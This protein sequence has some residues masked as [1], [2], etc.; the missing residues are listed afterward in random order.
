MKNKILVYDDN[1]PLCSWYSSLFVRCGLLPSDG[2][3]AFSTLDPSLLR[4]IDFNKSRNEIPLLDTGSGQVLY[5]IDALLEILGQRIS[6]IK[7][8]GH[9]QPVNWCLK[10]LYRFISYNRKVIVARKCGPGNIDCA[11]DMSYL[12]RVF[13]MLV[14][15]VNNTLLLFPLH[16]VVLASIPGFSL[17]TLQVQ[18]AHFS[19]VLINLVLAISFNKSM[20]IEYLGQVNML[21]LL[22][23]LLL[24]PLMLL[25]RYVDLPAWMIVL[26]LG[27]TAV[28]IFKEY[29]RRMEYA[30][31]LPGNKWI[32]SMNF[33][34]MMGFIVFLF[35]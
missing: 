31:V 26:Y 7:T 19:L 13:F 35:I 22:A 32:A 21:A 34:C 28:F 15:L 12:Y 30:G 23:I 14:F 18:A 25:M 20:A 24:M 16:D 2:R 8:V 27:F 10:K 4:L 9:V 3:K 5:G 1:C 17:S 29:L 11:P 6:F 33:V